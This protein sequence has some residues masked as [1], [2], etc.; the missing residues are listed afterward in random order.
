[1]RMQVHVKA[2]G[3][4]I[5]ELILVRHGKSGD[6]LVHVILDA[7][8]DTKVIELPDMPLEGLVYARFVA[9]G[10]LTI[11]AVDYVVTGP[12]RNDV[13]LT[14][15]IT[16]FRRDDAVQKT[17]ARLQRYFDRNPDILPDFDL[18]VIDNGGETDSI[19]FPKGRIIKNK[20]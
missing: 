17:S 9:V 18:L 5:L 1:N 8:G 2:T 20:N 19:G 6:K 3:R 7:Q 10:D 15:V 13:K 11:E 16:T 14:S 12:V 4:C